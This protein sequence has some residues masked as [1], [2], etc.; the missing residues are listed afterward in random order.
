MNRAIGIVVVIAIFVIAGINKAADSGHVKIYGKNID[1]DAHSVTIYINGNSYS[2]YVMPNE[3]FS[4]PFISINGNFN[5]TIIWY[6]PEHNA[7]HIISK[8]DTVMAG[9]YKE[10]EHNIFLCKEPLI[11]VHGWN[12]DYNSHNISIFVDGIKM[13]NISNIAPS[14][15]FES[16]EYE[17]SEGWRNISI[18]WQCNNESMKNY[19]NIYCSINQSYLIMLNITRCKDKYPPYVKVIYPNGGEI[20]KGKVL[21]SWIA[22]DNVDGRNLNI[23]IYYS[24]DNISWI[25]VTENMS[26]VENFLWNTLLINDG[27]YWLKVAAMDSSTNIGYDTSNA[28]FIIDNGEP[29]TS[30]ILDPPYKEWYSCNVTVTLIPYDAIT[31]IYVTKYKINNLRWVNYSIPFLINTEGYN[32]VKYYSIDNAGNKEEE[33]S[34][35]IRIDRSKPYTN[36]LLSPSMPNGNNG[37]YV[38]NV[39][40]I[41]QPID[42]LSGVNLTKYRIN[43]G[44]WLEYSSL[45]L[46]Q[47]GIYFIEYY[48]IDNAGNEEEIK[49]IEVKIDKS[50]PYTNAL[51]SPSMPNGNNGWYVSNVTLFLQAYDDTTGI[52]EIFYN[53]NGS[54]CEY[55]HE[56]KIS[57]EGI[58]TVKYYSIDNAGNEEEIKSIEVKI[59]KSKP[60]TNVIL[61]PKANE[62]GWHMTN[63]TVSMDAEDN[64]SG[65]NKTFYRINGGEWK[66]YKKEIKLTAEGN[67]SMEYYSIDNAG[68]EE[69]IKSIE[70]KIDKSKPLISIEKPE[71]GL[72]LFNRKI[73][74]LANNIIVIGKID[75]E[76][77]VKDGVSGIKN[78]DFYVDGE[79]KY[80]DEKEPY[81]WTYDELALLKHEI[82]IVAYDKAGNNESNK[83][84]IIVFNI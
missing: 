27:E 4:T 30:I 42:N 73:I 69:E 16:K 62:N 15:Y 34:I 76:V 82:E 36:A 17:V 45:V 71:K 7:F 70:I 49:S 50:K 33:K 13:E 35:Y 75:I 53:V 47:D 19:A 54:W 52:D 25:P 18:E 57:S 83:V 60:Y 81:E 6:C 2:Y 3:F 12:L 23:S 24:T 39:G 28:S 63:V 48:S 44:E 66:E 10:I 31:G 80:R 1:D 59:D 74:S 72:Y 37:W 8:N 64:A 55:V 61:S 58:N 65:I 20:L 26:N 5:Y 68:N 51:L 84:K 78:V 43:G 79:L 77:S 40:V 21:V 9:E 56:V 38:S 14:A 46:G 22:Y 29:D 67:Y 11:K 41:L 32:T